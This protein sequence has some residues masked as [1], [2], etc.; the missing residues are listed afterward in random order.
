MKPFVITAFLSRTGGSFLKFAN[1]TDDEMA[2]EKAIVEDMAKGSIKAFKKLC[3]GYS[4]NMV[5]Q[6]YSYLQDGRLAGEVVDT[7][8]DRLYKHGFRDVTFPLFNYL[9]DLVQKEVQFQRFLPACQPENGG[10][11]A[12]E[13]CHHLTLKAS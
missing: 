6:A 10:P 2:I 4:H 11:V 9:Y 12:L 3:M 1:M 8:L 7:V 13:Q 5:S